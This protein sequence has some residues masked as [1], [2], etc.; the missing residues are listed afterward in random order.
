MAER[1]AIVGIGQTYHQAR[2]PDVNDEELINEAVR[3]ALEDAQLTMRDID[4]VVIGNMDTFEGHYLNDGI[5]VNGTG[6]WL[7]PGIRVETGGTVGGTVSIAAWHHVASGMFDTVLAIAWEKLDE[8]YTTPAITTCFDLLHERPFVT[9]A[10]TPLAQIAQKYVTETGC[11]EEIGAIVRVKA[12]KNA[13]RNPHAHLKL[14]ISVEDVLKSRVVVYPLRLLHICPTTC[15]ACAL[16]M[17]SERKARKITNKPVWFKDHVTVHQECYMYVGGATYPPET[18]THTQAA[19]KLYRRNGIRN[20]MKDTQIFEMYDPASWC[21][22]AWMEDFLLCGKGE[23]WKLVEKGATHL[24]GEYP[25]NPSGGVVSTNPI[26][27]TAMVRVAEAAL[28]VRGDAGEHQVTREVNK[29]LVSSWGGCNWT[30]MMLL[31]KMPD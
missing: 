17:T 27:A 22:V 9:G 25:I 12:A 16:V 1:V 24:E 8:S 3:A 7:K 15:G 31:S 4:A 11:P 18:P 6:A 20:P 26:G 29:A 23:A 30:N 21:E 10:I 14:D 28:Q 19:I 13:I 2:R 5:F